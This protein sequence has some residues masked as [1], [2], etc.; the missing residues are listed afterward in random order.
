M[1]HNFGALTAVN[2]I[3]SLC[4]AEIKVVIEFWLRV[5]G[6][7]I[8]FFILFLSCLGIESVF[9]SFYVSAALNSVLKF[10]F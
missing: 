1:Q 5:G 3:K 10:L 8:S 6:F 2:T 4:C 7:L 9:F